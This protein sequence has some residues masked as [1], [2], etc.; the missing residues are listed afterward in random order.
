MKLNSVTQLG[1]LI[2]TAILIWLAVF[3]LSYH[4]FVLEVPIEITN[5]KSGW[6]INEDLTTVRATIRA[7]NMAYYQSHHRLAELEIMVL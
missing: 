4:S 1:L 2:S 6:A 3:S 7:K 5:L